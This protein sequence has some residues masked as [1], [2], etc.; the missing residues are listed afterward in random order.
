MELTV[1]STRRGIAMAVL[2]PL[3]LVALGGYGVG[4][5][6]FRF[7]PAAVLVVGALLLS[8]TLFDYPRRCRFT[9][10]GIVRVCF[11]RSQLLDWEEVHAVERSQAGFVARRSRFLRRNPGEPDSP[12]PSAGL[13]AR[14][15]GR[16]YLL[17]NRLESLR[18]WEELRTLMEEHAN[19]AF[20]GAAQPPLTTPPTRFPGKTSPEES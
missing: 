15:G 4:D 19:H 18:E 17:T 20:L 8:I 14:V 7:L 5:V 12:L 6:G 2:S 11:L 10:G 1:Y 9:P 16:R 13:V 3:F